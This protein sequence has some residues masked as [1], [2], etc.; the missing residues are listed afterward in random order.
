MISSPTPESCHDAESYVEESALTQVNDIFQ[1]VF[2][3]GALACMVA[4]KA[5]VYPKLV[6]DAWQQIKQQI[7]AADLADALRQQ[8]DFQDEDVG[9][10]LVRLRNGDVDILKTHFKGTSLC[11]WGDDVYDALVD[12]FRALGRFKP[13]DSVASAQQTNLSNLIELAYNASDED[14]QPV[15]DAIAR[16]FLTVATKI[17]QSDGQAR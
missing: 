11:L 4:G 13:F 16:Y 7:V 17:A 6:S 2:S 15:V 9:S 12:I 14:V 3:N 5:Y 10:M 8:I 1:K